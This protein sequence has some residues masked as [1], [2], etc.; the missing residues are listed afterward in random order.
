LIRSNKHTIN[1]NANNERDETCGETTEKA[2]L[3]FGNEA[4]SRK[5]GDESE[6]RMRGWL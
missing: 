1:S 3:V 4:S 6:V 2:P 5:E